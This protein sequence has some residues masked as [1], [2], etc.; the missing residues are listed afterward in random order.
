MDPDK[1]D[2][3]PNSITFSDTVFGS[4]NLMTMLLLI[5]LLPVFM[6]WIGKR[7][8][9]I[10]TLPEVSKEEMVI[11]EQA[12]GAERLDVS[13]IFSLFFGSLI[14][15][16]AIY[17][18]ITGFE[19]RGFGFITPNFINLLLLGLCL[20]LHRNIK[21]FLKAIDR[22][23]GGSSG[24]LI[25]FPLYFGI[26][27]IMTNSGL[28]QQFSDFFVRISSETISDLNYLMLRLFS[29]ASFVLNKFTLI[30]KSLSNSDISS[31]D[32]NLST[33][34]YNY[35]NSSILSKGLA[36]IAFP[37]LTIIGRSINFG[38]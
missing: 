22:A 31:V 19:I 18:A 32:L 36:I 10:T 3:L 8:K 29:I 27:G 6:Y 35:P 30:L 25:Q 4:M 7:T 13:R 33:C 28:A 24:I 37:S 20:S 1:L 14:V 9:K 21:Q 2:L 16:Y 17:V 26:L 38:Y 11:I 5:I 12:E 15:F 23:I 34:R